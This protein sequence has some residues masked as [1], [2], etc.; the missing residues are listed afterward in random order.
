M[1]TLF[2]KEENSLEPPKAQEAEII[3]KSTLPLSSFMQEFVAAQANLY[4]SRARSPE[5]TI[6]VSD[7]LGSIAHLYEKIR[8]VVEYKGEHVLRR[9]AI[10]RILKRLLWERSHHDTD[11]LSQVLIRELIWARYLPNDTVP[12]TKIKD[13]S[14]VIKKYLI[15]N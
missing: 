9:N 14:K 11:H 8:N 15:A 3:V 5:T 12:K 4:S 1:I 6:K 7:V 13:I 2:A 10:E